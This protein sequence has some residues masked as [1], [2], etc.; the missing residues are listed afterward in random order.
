MNNKNFII[1][2]IILAIVSVVGL[3]SYLPARSDSALKYKVGNFPKTIGE[4]TSKDLPLSERDY[5]ILETRN[6]F[7]REYKNASGEV[8]YFYLIY[9]EDNRKVSHPPEVCYMGSGATV[10]N[11]SSVQ[12]NNNL[13]AVKLLVDKDK[14]RQLV[15]Y[16]FK[17]GKTNTDQYLK[18]QSKIVL[19][20]MLGKR[21]SGAMI[22][23]SVDIKDDKDV[24]R[25]LAL[26][27]S[28]TA[29]IVP[30]LDKYVP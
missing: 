30:L 10:V 3:I 1:V 7:V 22:R 17:A 14:S 20:R 2:V 11:K 6:L 24:D 29:R 26:I 4:W 15:V 8:V 9:S 5:E 28:F 25:G 13:K 12:L 21:T 16:W 23:L 18:Q 19:D 27:K